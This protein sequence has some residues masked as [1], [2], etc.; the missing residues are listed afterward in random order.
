MSAPRA[1]VFDALAADARSADPLDQRL[2]ADFAERLAAK[3]GGDAPE[4][5][6]QPNPLQMLLEDFR[7]A[8]YKDDVRAWLAPGQAASPPP[9]PAEAITAIAAK[10][11]VIDQAWLAAEAARYTV[12]VDTV[13]RR[14]AAL[15]PSV[16]KVLTPRGEVPTLRALMIG[17]DG[18]RRRPVR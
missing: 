14:L 12:D 18:L 5:L 3:A 7:G 10:G 4:A 8:N 1:S 13:T 2:L 17:I 11:R 15:I 6:A 9:L 16:V